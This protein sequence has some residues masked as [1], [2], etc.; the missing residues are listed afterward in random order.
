MR[1]DIK[2]YLD[3]YELT[4]NMDL[5]EVPDFAMLP[6][7]ETEL[8][9]NQAD[10]SFELNFIM[11][12]S[13]LVTARD[14]LALAL[15]GKKEQ[16][17]TISIFENRYW[18]VE[19]NEEAS[20]IRNMDATSQITISVAFRLVKN[21]S[22]SKVIRTFEAYKN[23]DGILEFEIENNGTIPA[24]VNYQIKLKKES[25]FIGIVSQYGAMQFG[26]VDEAD[27]EWI[28]TNLSKEL[29]NNRN[30][31]FDNWVDGTIFYQDQ[32]K[33]SVTIMSANEN[34]GLGIL[35]PTFTNTVNAPF[36]GAIK[37]INF[38]ESS[39]NW[40]L[41]A[42]AWFEAGLVGQTGMWTIAIVDENNK[43]IAAYIIRKSDTLGNRAQVYFWLNGKVVKTIDFTPSQWSKDNPFGDES[44]KANRNPFDIR[45]E[46]KR[47]RFFW[48]GRYFNFDDSDIEN[49]KAKKIQFFV[50]Q[51]RGRNTGNQL[52]TR[53]NMNNISFTKLNVESFRDDP[54]RFPN[55]STIYINGS[56]TLLY[57]NNLP[58]TE[59][60]IT[61]T[62]WFKVPPGETKVQLLISDFS[63]VESAIAEMKEEYI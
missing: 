30:G 7:A 19:V 45:K 31:N 33:K 53:I 44:K 43:A 63:E 34:A 25:G 46:G 2:I 47:V 52:V 8:D 60:E 14:D 51:F 3:E 32:N 20:F 38:E 17:L 49:V 12:A 24:P 15:F 59:D 37:E 54:N 42:Q 6:L 16:E 55:N 57:L 11:D 35:P 28:E 22:Y 50:G 9:E 58:R 5:T 13:D 21:R 39:R 18:I 4:K 40:Y 29:T 62:V 56:E 27:G 26:K 48:A 36:F 10:Y 1:S 41:W 61:G 23:S